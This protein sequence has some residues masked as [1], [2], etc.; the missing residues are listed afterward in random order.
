[1]TLYIMETLSALLLVSSYCSS[2]LVVRAEEF[3]EWLKS[4]KICFR[5][6]CSVHQLSIRLE[7]LLMEVQQWMDQAVV[8]LAVCADCG[9]FL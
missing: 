6:C 8:A 4:W 7:V 3:V 5:C 2:S 9:W 1:M